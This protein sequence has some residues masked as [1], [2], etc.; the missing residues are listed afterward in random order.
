LCTPGG[1]NPEVR[2]RRWQVAWLHDKERPGCL[3]SNEK[4]CP[5][6]GGKKKRSLKNGGTLSVVVEGGCKKKKMGRQ[7]RAPWGRVG[8]EGNKNHLTARGGVCFAQQRKG[9]QRNP[10]LPSCCFHEKSEK[11]GKCVEF[12]QGQWILLKSQK[13][14]RMRRGNQQ[15]TKQVTPQSSPA[16]PKGTSRHGGDARDGNNRLLGLLK[17]AGGC[18]KQL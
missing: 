18:Q 7:K 17:R 1:R 16:S 15:W 6:R 5:R 2:I 9:E 11:R 8:L 12:R 13:G 14:G 10:F 4:G 3:G